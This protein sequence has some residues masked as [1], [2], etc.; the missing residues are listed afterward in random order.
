MAK[1][2]RRSDYNKYIEVRELERKQKCTGIPV[3]ALKKPKHLS[4]KGK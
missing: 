4:K 2:K 3:T 1:K